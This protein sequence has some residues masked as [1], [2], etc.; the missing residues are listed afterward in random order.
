MYRWYLLLVRAGNTTFGPEYAQGGWWRFSPDK[1]PMGSGTWDSDTAGEI[2]MWPLFYEAAA[3]TKDLPAM[4]RP[5]ITELGQAAIA[6]MNIV[7]SG[8]FNAWDAGKGI[9]WLAGVDEDG[10]D[11]ANSSLKRGDRYIPLPP[12]QDTD[13]TPQVFHSAAGQTSSQ[14]FTDREKAISF[15]ATQLGMGEAFGQ[16]QSRGT[17]ATQS[18]DFTKTQVPRIVKAAF[19][20]ETAQRRGLYWLARRFGVTPDG[21]IQWPRSFDLVEVMDAIQSF[22]TVER[23]SGI[24]SA[25]IDAK[26]M[27]MY[28]VEKRLISTDEE[29]KTV[30]KEYEESAFQRD[31]LAQAQADQLASRVLNSNLPPSGQTPGGQDTLNQPGSIGG[32]PKAGVSQAKDRAREAGKKAD[33][34]TAKRKSKIPRQGKV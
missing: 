13:A 2:P 17:G 18:A 1:E 7:S 11:L 22:F 28:A 27:T 34:S 9:E 21:S 10:M 19:N 31:Q 25:T 23:L 24:R 33:K 16:T 15:V 32:P 14:T 8:N 3:G 6:Y 26:A 30:L 29:Q 12:N 5:G 20:L 4:S